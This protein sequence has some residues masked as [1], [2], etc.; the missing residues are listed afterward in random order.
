[1]VPAEIKSKILCALDEE[2]ERIGFGTVIIK[3]TVLKGR[4]TNAK[5]ETERSL[6]LNDTPEVG[7][8]HQP[9]N[10]KGKV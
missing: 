2:V 4:A 3:V 5:Y 7:V 8:F 6:N 9:Q 10:C 1:M